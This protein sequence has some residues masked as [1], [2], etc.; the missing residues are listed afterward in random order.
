MIP[1]WRP[2]V[3]WLMGSCLSVEVNTWFLIAR[4]SFNKNGDKPFTTGVPLL[5]SFRLLIVSTCFYISWFVIRLGF[6]PYLLILILREHY[7]LTKEVGSIFNILF[8]AP[9]F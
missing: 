9:L 8:V 6:Y 1:L 4:R 2:Q 7:N 3:G 5:K